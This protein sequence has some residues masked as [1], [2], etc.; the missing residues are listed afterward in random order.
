MSILF[1]FYQLFHLCFFLGFHLDIFS[2]C[3][4]L[5]ELFFFVNFFFFCFDIDIQKEKSLFNQTLFD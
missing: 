1:F 3:S 2:H 5:L 4:F